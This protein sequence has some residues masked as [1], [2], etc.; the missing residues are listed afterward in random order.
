MGLLLAADMVDLMLSLAPRDL[1]T[2]QFEVIVT[3]EGVTPETG[4]S[5]QVRQD[6]KHDHQRMMV[7]LMLMI[8]KS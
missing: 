3:V 2:W 1:Q 7:D 4:C 8:V 5:V 6:G